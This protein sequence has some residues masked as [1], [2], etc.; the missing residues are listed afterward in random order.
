[1]ADGE[2]LP[3]SPTA[4]EARKA[5]G[6]ARKFARVA[7]RA[8]ALPAPSTAESLSMDAF[9]LLSLEWEWRCWPPAGTAGD[10]REPQPQ[11]PPWLLVATKAEAGE[12][13]SWLLVAA[14]AGRVV[15]IRVDDIGL[16]K[17]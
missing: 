1:M 17:K 8:M 5:V 9:L 15:G 4:G 12:A 13:M 14:E 16:G 3:S 11:P 10:R 6:L 7:A 2:R